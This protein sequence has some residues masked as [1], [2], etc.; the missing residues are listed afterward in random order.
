LENR[1]AL[2]CQMGLFVYRTAL[3]E[4]SVYCARLEVIWAEQF[5]RQ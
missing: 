1:T 5:L 3:E 4:F 2:H